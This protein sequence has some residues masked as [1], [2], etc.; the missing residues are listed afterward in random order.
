M[1]TGTLEVSS[2]TVTPA[3][4]APRLPAESSARAVKV[5]SPSAR[6]PVVGIAIRQ[7]AG[8]RTFVIAHDKACDLTRRAGINRDWEAA[9]LR[10]YLTNVVN[11]FRDKRMNAVRQFRRVEAPFALGIGLGFTQQGG[12]VRAAINANRHVGF[13]STGQ[14]Q[15][16]VVVS[17]VRQG[18]RDLKLPGAVSLYFG[19]A[20]HLVAVVHGDGVARF[21][22]GAF[23][24]RRVIVSL[25]A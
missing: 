13:R 25:T 6:E 9:S 21:R 10:A 7:Y 16:V 12:T 19:G 3:F 4:S 15:G 24:Q 18:F 14:K 20:N 11:R 5:Y 23:D 2:V 22:A 8:L 1:V 17:P